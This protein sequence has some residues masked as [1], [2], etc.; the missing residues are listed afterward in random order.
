MR[1]LR[2]VALVTALL[3]VV[4]AVPSKASATASGAESFVAEFGNKMIDL[5]RT[6]H[7]SPRELEN[8]IRPLVLAAFDAPRISR[9]VLG[10]YWLGMSGVDRNAFTQAF[11]N[12]I[13]H[14]YSERFSGHQA[15]RFAVT[16]AEPQGAATGAEPQGAAAVLVHSEITPSDGGAPIKLDWLTSEVAG[17]FKIVDVGVDGLSQ[18]L[19]YREEFASVIENHG[20]NVFD[21]IAKLREKAKG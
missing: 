9:Y 1:A 11:E 14:V 21:L 2:A 5:V 17:Q 20:G 7:G 13:V 19:T 8:N 6:N 4:S 10:R 15:K 16:G 12:Y 18:V 3:L